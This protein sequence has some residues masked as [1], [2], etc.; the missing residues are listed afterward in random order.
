M[1]A[2]TEK[3]AL[4]FGAS[5]IT[6]HPIARL[7]LSY[8]TPTSFRRVIGLTARSLA[9]AEAGF[10]ADPRLE[11]YSGLDLSNGEES[12]RTFLQGIE[13]IGEVTNVY[14][15]G[16]SRLPGARRQGN[17]SKERSD[18]DCLYHC[19]ERGGELTRKPAYVH[20]GWGAADSAS[21]AKENVSLVINA[22]TALEVVCPNL[23]FFTFATG[24]K[25][26]QSFPEHI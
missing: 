25:V 3:T 5:G 8:P 16:E 14:F 24:G 22:I 18:R 6:G 12:T 9:I 21:R 26:R 15:A 7:C 2:L 1:G 11:L 19:G 10:P 17:K 4:I 13:G 23:E 20:L